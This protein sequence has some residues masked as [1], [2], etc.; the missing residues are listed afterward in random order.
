MPA[1]HR[2]VDPSCLV[3]RARGT[4]ARGAWREPGRVRR[5][6]LRRRR[7]APRWGFYEGA[8][9]RKRPAW[10]PTTCSLEC[11]RTSSRAIAPCAGTLVDRKGG[12][13]C[14]R[15]ACRARPWRPSSAS[16]PRPTSS[17]F[18]IAEFNARCREKHPR[19][20]RRGLERDDRADLGF[21]IDLDDAYRT[22]DPQYVESVWWALKTIHDKGLLY[23]EAQGRPLLPPATR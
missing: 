17:G 9:D 21:W 16:P 23:R 15:A 3:P 5:V 13:T 8:A 19:Q 6:D 1:A 14:R 11:S 18:G 7:D 12:W 22:L 4:R 2:P 10:L 20:P